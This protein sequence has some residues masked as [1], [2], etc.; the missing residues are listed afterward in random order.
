MRTIKF[1][2]T[3]KTKFAFNNLIV[4]EDAH[5]FQLQQKMIRADF[6]ISYNHFM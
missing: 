4:L 5:F 2:F 6:Q 1:F 3:L